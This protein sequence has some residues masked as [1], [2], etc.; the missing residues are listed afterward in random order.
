MQ[1]VALYKD[2]QGNNVFKM[3]KFEVAQK[4]IPTD[5]CT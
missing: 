1:M 4:Q 2:P 3:L 5:A